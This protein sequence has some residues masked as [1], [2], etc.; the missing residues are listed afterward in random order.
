[1]F[2]TFIIYNFYY[3]I[4]ILQRR[5]WEVETQTQNQMIEN[6][7][8]SEREKYLEKRMHSL[9][10]KLQ[11][12]LLQFENFQK[13]FENS[14]GKGKGKGRGKRQRQSSP[15][16]ADEVNKEAQ[17]RLRSFLNEQNDPIPSTSRSSHS[18]GIFIC[19][20]FNI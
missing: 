18:S 19:F 15:D 7:G 4:D 10:E 16:F 20:L 17:R 11:E 3:C 5:L 2:S 12:K 8:P 13:Q 9:E 6:Q 1:M 14:K